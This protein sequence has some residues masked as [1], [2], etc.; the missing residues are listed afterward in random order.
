MWSLYAKL[1]LGVAIKSSISALIDS[2][3]VSLV[4]VP[5]E[6]FV[7]QV[8]Y[9]DYDKDMIPQ[10]NL[11]WPYVY[12]RKSFEHEKE[13]R[14]VA[15]IFPT[16]EGT[17]NIDI[18]GA[19]SFSCLVDPDQLIEEVYVAPA[20]GAWYRD[21]VQVTSEKF[22]LIRETRHSSLDVDPVY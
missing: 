10:N 21:V 20:S 17:V 22:G 2:L 11:F 1:G 16:Y 7:G 4:D 5:E 8:N 19:E 15:T 3:T 12:K 14:L 9:V 6:I 18:D 13:L